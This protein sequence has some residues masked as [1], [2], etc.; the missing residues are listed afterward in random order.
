MLFYTILICLFSILWGAMGLGNR[1]AEA[2][3]PKFFEE[4]GGEDITSGYPG[5]EYK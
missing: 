4:F 1:T 3:N 5:V 2:V